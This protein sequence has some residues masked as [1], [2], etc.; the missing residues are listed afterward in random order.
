MRRADYVLSGSPLIREIAALEETRIVDRS[1]TCEGDALIS[2]RVTRAAV[3]TVAF[4]TA[5]LA[6]DT[7]RPA[8]P[9]SGLGPQ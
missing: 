6:A 3:F 4:A 1:N 2:F 8:G 7:A 9:G 5:W